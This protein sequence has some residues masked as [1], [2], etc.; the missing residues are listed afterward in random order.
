MIRS[1]NAVLEGGSASAACAEVLR[2]GE[3]RTPK[4]TRRVLGGFRTDR[5]EFRNRV[6]DHKEEEGNKKDFGC[7]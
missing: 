2:D 1:R 7:A 4:K 6:G 5:F 3:W